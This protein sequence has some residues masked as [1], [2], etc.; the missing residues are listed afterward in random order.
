[1]KILKTASIFAVIALALFL[2]THRLTEVPPSL[3]IDEAAFGYNALSIIET[4]RDEFGKRLPLYFHSFYT[5][6]NPVYSYSVVASVGVFGMNDFAVRLPAA[7]FGTLE[8]LFLYLL[9]LQMGGGHWLALLAAL[10]LGISPW[11]FHHSRIGTEPITLSCFVAAAAFCLVRSLRFPAWAL[12]AGVLF[13]LCLYCY[14][15]AFTFVPLILVGFF[16]LFRKNVLENR[17]VY[18]V[19]GFI[20]LV[21]FIPHLLPGLKGEEQAEHFKKILITH[22]VNTQFNKNLLRQSPP[23]R[24]DWI[25]E[26]DT[27]RPAAVFLRNYFATFGRGYLFEHGDT[28]TRRHH[29]SGFGVLFRGQMIFI[30]LG[31]AAGLFVLGDRRFFALFVL[32]LLAFPLG[33]SL[34]VQWVPMLTRTI[35]GASVFAVFTALGLAFLWKQGA[36]RIKTPSALHVYRLI[37]LCAALP[38]FFNAADYFGKYFN[39]YP[40]E[41]AA[42]WG[43]GVR[44][45]ILRAEELKDEYDV[46]IVDETINFVYMPV[47]YYTGFPP[48]RLL[49]ESPLMWR[50]PYRVGMLGKYLVGPVIPC[51]PD[52][53]CLYLTRVPG[54]GFATP[55]H[56]FG[57]PNVERTF[58]LSE[59]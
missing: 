31:V 10:L 8:V 13:G 21:L 32:W 18:L 45:G 40:A 30:V 56:Y 58:V 53:K 1:M 28:S 35:C 36:Q 44:E 57:Y 41:S 14:A 6:K 22:P 25:V 51:M 43:Y 11:S 50:G 37:L 38:I 23:Y 46:V 3:L 12:P 26:C 52:K 49:R 15:P 39:D 24:A 55:L 34:T 9:V 5:G 20:F 16:L 27:L 29:V 33:S 17:K 2:R 47:L 59:D 19:S 54:P 7:I 48:E 42:A 4:G